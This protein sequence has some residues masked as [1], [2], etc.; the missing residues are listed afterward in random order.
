LQRTNGEIKNIFDSI[1]IDSKIS[2]NFQ[3]FRG[4]WQVSILCS[5]LFIIFERKYWRVI[6]VCKDF[7]S[8]ISSDKIGWKT[9]GMKR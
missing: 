3:M 4:I 7:G 1:I 5:L 6:T 2:E 9:G 8:N